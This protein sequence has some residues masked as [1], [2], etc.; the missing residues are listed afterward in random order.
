MFYIPEEWLVDV[1]NDEKVHSILSKLNTD[2]NANINKVIMDLEEI[3]ETTVIEKIKDGT[4]TF[5]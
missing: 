5:G 3:N 1:N 2:I 4:I